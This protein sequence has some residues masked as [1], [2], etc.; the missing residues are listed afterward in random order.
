[1]AEPL[2]ESLRLFS[3]GL[4][5]VESGSVGT[6]DRKP[7]PVFERLGCGETSIGGTAHRKPSPVFERLG[8]W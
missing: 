1:M 5:A 2:I 4:A 6:D 7:S 8:Y 3:N